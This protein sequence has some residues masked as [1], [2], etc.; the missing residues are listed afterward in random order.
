MKKLIALLL[1]LMLT[2]SMFTACGDDDDDDKDSKTKV[3]KVESVE[4]ALDALAKADSIGAVTYKVS[5]DAGDQGTFDVT[6]KAAANGED[7]SMGLSYKADIN[8]TSMDIDC[9]ELVIVANHSA[10][11]NLGVIADVM[12][13]SE[14]ISLSDLGVDEKDLTWFEIPLPDDLKLTA[15]K[16]EN[17]AND[18]MDFLKDIL[19][20]GKADGTKVTFSELSQL[21]DA[22]N[23]LADFIEN[24]LSDVLKEALEAANKNADFA[25][26]DINK[27]VKKLIDFYYDDVCAICDTLGVDSDV[28]DQY[29]DQIESMDLQETYD[30][31]L[32]QY[33]SEMSDPDAILSDL[34]LSDV[35]AEIREEAESLEDNN[36][37]VTFNLTLEADSDDTVYSFDLT[38]DVTS[39][40]ETVKINATMEFDL[41]APSVKA[42]TDTCQLRDFSDLITSLLTVYMGGASIDYDDSDYEYETEDS[43][44]EWEAYSFEEDTETAEW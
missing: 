42:P 38:G 17:L 27:Y 34:N 12:A 8:G 28:V 16:D 18:A 36:E 44:D 5:M 20:C 33:E 43:D 25:E 3:E 39:Q 21:K 22:M 19:K 6:V 15:S 32:E 30:Q 2:M 35:V 9:P 37:D 29:V 23:V 31:Y 41:D 7:M 1:C 11:I 13:L 10:F 24:D 26:I 4:D 40:D 14:D